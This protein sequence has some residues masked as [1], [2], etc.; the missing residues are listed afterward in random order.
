MTVDPQAVES[1]NERAATAIAQYTRHVPDFPIPGIMFADL[2]PIFAQPHGLRA[3]VDALAEAGA[4]SHLVAGID[5]RGFL[6]GAGVALELGV[7]VVAVRK[8]GKLPPPVSSET[9]SL[10]YGTAT[11]EIPH[12]CLELEGR[13]V[14]VV[15]DVLATGG[16]VAATVA[17]LRGAGA[18]VS[19]V[20][21]V[22]ELDGLGGREKL[23][24]LPGGAI[25]VTALSVG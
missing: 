21:V 16:T 22:M 2:T 15:D 12:G 20:A 24:N 13:R 18:I 19:T 17:L 3:V 9:Y 8:S 14:L 5:A 4:G 6:V 11:L 23:S 1:V 7:G 25:S 10:E